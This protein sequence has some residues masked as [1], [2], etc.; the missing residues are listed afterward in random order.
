MPKLLCY[1]LCEI[2]RTANIANN[3]EIADF[4]ESAIFADDAEITVIA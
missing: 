1:Q 3:D 4:A 2:D